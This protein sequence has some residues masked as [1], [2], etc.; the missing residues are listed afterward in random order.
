MLKTTIIIFDILKN[1][2]IYF[3]KKFGFKNILKNNLTFHTAPKYAR[4]LQSF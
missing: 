3:F 4:T 2:H 1:N